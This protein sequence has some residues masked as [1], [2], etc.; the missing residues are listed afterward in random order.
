MRWSEHLFRVAGAA[1]WLSLS[2]ARAEPAPARSL[3]VVSLGGLDRLLA[4]GKTAEGVKIPSP[5]ETG[6]LSSLTLISKITRVDEVNFSLQGLKIISFDNK[7]TDPKTGKPLPT[8][9]EI[10]LGTYNEPSKTLSSDQPCRISKP[11]FDLTG[12]SLL[13]DSTS[14]TGVMKGKVRMVIYQMDEPKGAK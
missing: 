9:I 6:G 5:S 11:E 12:Q 14:G 3:P 13:Y 4:V 7:Q 10:S 8:T 1:C 2:I